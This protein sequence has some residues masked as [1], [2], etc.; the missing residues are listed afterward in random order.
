MSQWG[1]FHEWMKCVAVVTF[2]LELGQKMEY[3]F[4]PHVKLSDKVKLFDA[5][6]P[7]TFLRTFFDK[8]MVFLWRFLRILCSR[9][10]FHDLFSWTSY[11]LFSWTIYDLFCELFTNFF[12]EL[13][14]NFFSWTFYKL[15][16][17]M[18]TFTNFFHELLTNF[19]YEIFTT[20]FVN[21][22]RTFLVNFFMNIFRTFFVKFYHMYFLG[23]FSLN[24]FVTN[25]WVNFYIKYN[26]FELF[27]MRPWWTFCGLFFTIKL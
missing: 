23:T 12:C 15:F 27:S 24:V 10:F 26:L 11:E 6:F 14:T 8:L 17:W 21:F 9:S 16:P 19:F 4:P 1:R 5:L 20:F 22:L 25:V 18:K 3:C 13:L 7:I 2:D